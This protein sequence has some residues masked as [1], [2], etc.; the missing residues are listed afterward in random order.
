[1][2]QGGGLGGGNEKNKD[3]YRSREKETKEDS[4]WA[5]E[6]LPPGRGQAIPGSQER[7]LAS[8]WI[9]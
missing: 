6:T 1:M 2:R 7:L 8:Y 9:V 5:G 4:H 3:I